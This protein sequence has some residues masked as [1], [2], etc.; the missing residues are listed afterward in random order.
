[1]ID[2]RSVLTNAIVGAAFMA[3]PGKTS[4]AGDTQ[5]SPL[6][7]RP[8]PISRVERKA[9]IEKAQLLMRQNGF[10]AVLME[11]GASMVYFTGIHWRRNERPTCAI[12]PAE[13]EI[14]IVTPFFEEPSIRET[15]E[16]PAEVRTW[17]EHEDAL[18][19]VAG[20][21]RDRKLGSGAVG[22]E[23]TTRYFI[24]DRLKSDLPSATVR[25]G[26]SVVRGCRLVKSPAEIALMQYAADITIAAYRHTIPRIAAG[27]RP[28]AISAIM[29]KAHESL[30]GTSEFE[31]ALIGEAAA[32][33]HGSDKPQIVRPGEI[34][35]MDCGCSVDGYQSD[36]SRTFVFGTPTRRQRQVWDQVK[37]GQLI[38]FEKAQIGVAAG[39]VDAAVRAYY[40]SLGYGPEYRLPGLSHR[41]GH[42]I[43]LDGHEPFNLVKNEA[44]KLVPGT[45]FS[46]EPGLYIPGEFGV[47]LEDCF[48]MTDKGPKWF[49]TPSVSIEEPV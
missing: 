37:T 38:A 32:Y 9:R 23:E 19:I 1:M 30:G 8:T 5:L 2:R 49:S 28:A 6:A 12:I 29:K 20:W 41:T 15:L 47:R 22:I 33:P 14:G 43:G 17:L 35:L 3:M 36:I 11:P 40:T 21:L 27:M 25:N 45:C 42:G 46:D 31:D 26:A 16:V 13:G 10:A 44:S 39:D 4:A 24:V 34:V 48:H 7:N 18:S